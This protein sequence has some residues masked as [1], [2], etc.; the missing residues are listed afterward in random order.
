LLIA[1]MSI[2]VDMG[3]SLTLTAGGDSPILSKRR[4]ATC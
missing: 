4:S 2:D 1:G 3:A